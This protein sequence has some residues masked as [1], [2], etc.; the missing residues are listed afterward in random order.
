MIMASNNFF[1]KNFIMY[2]VSGPWDHSHL[3]LPILG[4]SYLPQA[5]KAKLSNLSTSEL[6]VSL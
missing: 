3:S 2:N 6:L 5:K 4:I 1:H